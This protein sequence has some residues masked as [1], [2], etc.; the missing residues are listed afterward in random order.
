MENNFLRESFDS[1]Q[2]TP[3]L[4]Y[5]LCE[6]QSYCQ[7]QNNFT[8]IS[9]S[10]PPFPNLQFD[11]YETELTLSFPWLVQRLI[12]TLCDLPAFIVI[13]DRNP[14]LLIF[15]EC[16]GIRATGKNRV[17]DLSQGLKMDTA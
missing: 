2:M 17:Q 11:E 8:S 14:F 7:C 5:E 16:E 1:C 15:A 13:H 3:E 4:P 9:G 10:S 6:R 12:K